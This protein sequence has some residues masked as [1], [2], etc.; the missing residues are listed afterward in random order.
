MKCLSTS[1]DKWLVGSYSYGSDLH[2]KAN[3]VDIHILGFPVSGREKVKSLRKSLLSRQ[4]EVPCWSLDECMS[5]ERWGDLQG[6]VA[7]LG[8]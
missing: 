6:R 8:Y 3:E 2:V 5:Y 4:E 1:K 7:A